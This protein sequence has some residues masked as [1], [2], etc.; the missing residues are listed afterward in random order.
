LRWIQ[1]ILA[2]ARDNDVLKN[3]ILAPLDRV[4]AD[5]SGYRRLHHLIDQ[6]HRAEREAMLAKLTAPNF[7][8]SMFR[9]TFWL[10]TAGS[11]HPLGQQPARLFAAAILE[12]RYQSLQKQM[13]KFQ[14]FDEE[15]RHRCRIEIKKLRYAL[16]FLGGLLSDRHTAKFTV[17]LAAL[18]DCLGILNDIA[19]ARRTLQ[20]ITLKDGQAD[21]AWAAG[22]VAGWHQNRAE[23]LLKQALDSWHDL[24]KIPP[25]WHEARL[26]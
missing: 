13:K 24:Q 11:L 2:P 4:Y 17:R 10:E 26:S 15:Q 19:T 21:I 14:N 6:R 1:Q 12:R 9:L 5:L 7:A 3:E 22:L 25:F 18:Q 23:G 8:K 16:D 20:E